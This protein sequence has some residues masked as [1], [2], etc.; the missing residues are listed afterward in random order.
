MKIAFGL[1]VLVLAGIASHVNPAHAD[2]YGRHGKRPSAVFTI[3]NEA[4]ANR[5][6]SFAVG[7]DGSLTAAGSFATS[8]TGTG[9]SLG[10]QAALVLSENRR[11][12][13]AVNAGSNDVSVF[14]VDGTRLELRSR[15]ASG[16]TRPISVTERSGLVYVV[17]A[18]APNIIAGFTLDSRGRLSPI[19]GSKRSLSAPDSGPGQ[20]ELSPDGRTLVVTEKTS[21]VITSFSV[22]AYGRLGRPVTTKSA[23]MTPFGFEFTERGVLVVSEAA[24]ASMSSYALDR[25]GLNVISSAVPDTQMAPCWV[26]ISDEA[27]VAYT[28][29]AASASI[30]SYDLS[31]SGEL[32]LKN[33]KA[34]DLGEKGN[35]LDLAFARGGRYLFA[36]DRGNTRIVGYALD[37]DGALTPL[38]AAAGDL[39][40]FTTGLAAY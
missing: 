35:P 1:G 25:S 30:S 39:P 40:A 26:A 38:P 31:R 33:A 16:G 32:V 11:F 7:K 5:V 36:L 9:D 34:A 17:N 6:L 4:E 2:D 20:I 3:T 21:N 18:G 8:G 19:Y 10:S 13:I 22:D 23:G 24:T 28:A 15:T 37:R 12:L 14:E 29:N 27:R